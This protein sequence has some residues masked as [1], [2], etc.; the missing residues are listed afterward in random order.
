MWRA[1]ATA[2]GLQF[3]ATVCSTSCFPPLQDTRA[4][5]EQRSHV[6][7]IQKGGMVAQGHHLWGT[8]AC[9]QSYTCPCGVRHHDART[10]RKNVIGF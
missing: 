3:T 7:S 6:R 4:V 8:N 1:L 10:S 2:A 5:P 9:R